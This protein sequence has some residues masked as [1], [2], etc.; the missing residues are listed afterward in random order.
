VRQVSEQDFGGTG[1]LRLPP[2]AQRP[3]PRQPYLVFQAGASI[4]TRRAIQIAVLQRRVATAEW[5]WADRQE[6]W[7]DAGSRYRR[8]NNRRPVRTIWHVGVQ[9]WTTSEL[10]SQHHRFSSRCCWPAPLTS[11]T[12]EERRVDDVARRFSQKRSNC[13]QWFAAPIIAM[14][15]R[16]SCDL[17]VG[18]VAGLGTHLPLHV[19]G[20]R[21]N[22][23]TVTIRD[24]PCRSRTPSGRGQPARYRDSE[25]GWVLAKRAKPPWALLRR[26]IP[27]QG[28]PKTVAASGSAFL[29]KS[30]SPFLNIDGGI[31]STLVRQTAGSGVKASRSCEEQDR[32]VDRPLYSRCSCIYKP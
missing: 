30:G 11:V 14:F 2:V 29:R 7:T 4:F 21:R 25:R 3:A 17:P 15:L 8:Y 24:G 18:G 19:T 13:R 32:M 31:G 1:R 12:A 6:G 27:H 28:S 9:P 20:G 22:R 16:D 26:R 10:Q 5:P 23:A